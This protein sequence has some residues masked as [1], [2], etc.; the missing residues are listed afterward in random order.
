[1]P[2]DPKDEFKQPIKRLLA[3][4]VGFHCSNPSCGISTVGPS[5]IPDEKE[6]IGVAAHIFS[7]SVDDGPRANPLLSSE[8]RSSINNAIHLCQTCS[9]LI[10]KNNGKGYSAEVLFNWK[11]AAEVA[12]NKRIYQKKP[13]ILYKEIEFS[14]LEKDYSTALTCAGL[15]EKNINSCPS[16]NLI[17]TDIKNK[18]NLAYKCLLKGISGSGKSVLTYQVAHEFYKSGWSVFKIQKDLIADNSVV[19]TPRD[20]SFLIIDDAQTI[21]PRHLESILNSAH[22]NC[23]VLA[24]WNSSTSVDSKFINSYPYYEITPYLQVE[25]LKNYCNK[26]KD[27]I[28]KTLGIIGLNLNTKD[29]FNRI[30]SRID[31]A[32]NENTP[33]EFNYHLSEGWNNAK[34]DYSLLRGRE[35]LNLVI[36]TVAIFQF[37]TLDNGVNE[38]VILSALKE[39]NQS[40]K[41]LNNAQEVIS[42]YCINQDGLVRNKHY[43][44]SR[45]ILNI[46]SSQKDSKI[47]FKYLVNL[48]ASILRTPDFLSGH[49]NILE[50]VLFYFDWGK[51]E[52]NRS[53]AISEIAT[54][55]LSDKESTD[56]LPEKIRKLDS[57]IRFNKETLGILD[58]HVETLE[59]WLL[60]VNRESAYQLANLCNTLS[61]EKFSNFPS[62]LLLI[63]IVIKNIV[64]S[65]IE[66]KSRF[67]HLVNRIYMHL[68][69]DER[70]HAN[71]LLNNSGFSISLSSH[72]NSVFCY[73]FSSLMF[74]L[75]YIS[76]SWTDAQIENSIDGIAGLLNKN[77]MES[78]RDLHDLMENNFGIIGA[79]LGLD[80]NKRLVKKCTLLSNKILTKSVVDAFELVEAVDVQEYSFI[81]IFFSLYNKK[82]LKEISINFNYKRLENLFKSDKKLDHHHSVLIKLLY[83]PECENYQNHVC[84]IINN[85]DYI[86]KLFIALSPE[87]S[88]QRLLSGVKYNLDF[89]GHEECDLELDILK[90]LKEEKDGTVLVQR[91]LNENSDTISEA[92]FTKVTNIDKTKSKFELLI[93]IHFVS[94]NLYFGMFEDDNRNIILIEKITRLIKGTKNEKLLAKLYVKFL[95]L[96][97]KNRIEQL[98]NIK[99]RYR[100]IGNFD[101]DEFSK[102]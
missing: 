43:E 35:N 76:R 63:D 18:L 62:S 17:I 9:V 92:I 87:L 79:I 36:V 38:S 21:E 58:A 88:H 96:Y 48:I 70:K 28:S 31:R 68:S 32:A 67:A 40:D 78:Y 55:L 101:I 2:R 8:E 50:Y 12:A 52:L 97:S 29:Q 26:N 30:E 80:N 94:P 45:V 44:Y 57:I 98:I 49:S 37:A 47:E 10:D 5:V 7:A 3:E 64:K 90:Q 60:S 41:W 66:D 77:L 42:H 11:S 13:Y 54:E 23:I 71:E 72:S 93:F 65:D 33:W 83:N 6:Y 75:S 39:F 82:K 59:N 27:A 61:N 84:N 100:S 25:L 51:F 102:L 91:I 22:E 99:K 56:C 14:F 81:L 85:F 1:M 74:N 46:F 4:R 34:Q 15:N 69:E 95:D 53:G 86:D 24:N 89:P 16:N 73:Q 20:K 19:I